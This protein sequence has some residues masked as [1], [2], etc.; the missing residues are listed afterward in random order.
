M[1]FLLSMKQFYKNHIYQDIAG[2]SE[3]YTRILD[4]SH[5]RIWDRNSNVCHFDT[6]IGNISK[7]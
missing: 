3:I 6:S 4:K 5:V 1:N 7:R 2:I